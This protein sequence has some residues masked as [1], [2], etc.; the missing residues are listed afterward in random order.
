MLTRRVLLCGLFAWT[1]FASTG[2]CGALRN[3]V[4]RWRMNHGCCAPG[5]AG[6]CDG[7]YCTPSFTAPVSAGPVYGGAPAPGCATCYSP[8]VSPEVVAHGAPVAGP[9]YG[10]PLHAPAPMN[11]PGVFQTNEPPMPM[12]PK[13]SN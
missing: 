11:P 4:Y 12:P 3:C 1:A 9:V 8:P 13:A 6:P 2:C 10:A 5:F 7:G